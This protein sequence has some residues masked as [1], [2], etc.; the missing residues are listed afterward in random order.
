L[1][2]VSP[3]FLPL[4]VDQVTVDG[5]FNVQGRASI[6]TSSILFV[7]ELSEPPT[8]GGQRVEAARFSRAAVRLRVGDYEVRGFMHVPGRGDPTWR[9]NHE[10]CK[11]IA[12]TSASV[13]GPGV[14]FATPFLAVN[15]QHISAAQ[16][17]HLDEPE[18]EQVLCAA[19]TGGA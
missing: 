19:E 4:D 8:R 3:G 5:W 1:N 12:V 6:N 2:V 18:P 9:L 17:I 7:R 15:R 13:V 14:E 16:E 10:K 11:F